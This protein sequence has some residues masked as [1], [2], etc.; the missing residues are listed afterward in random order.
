VEALVKKYLTEYTYSYERQRTE[1]YKE[2]YLNK[3]KEVVDEFNHEG[4]NK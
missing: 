1:V 3:V 4:R 2:E